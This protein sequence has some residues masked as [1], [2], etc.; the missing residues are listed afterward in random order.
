MR[1]REWMSMTMALLALAPIATLASE[2]DQTRW[3]LSAFTWVK[4]V[5]AEPGAPP[6]A[7]P[8]PLGAE[9]LQALLIPV[10]AKVDGK[11]IPLFGKD[12]LKDLSK[13]LSEAL[14][15]AQPGEDL[16]LISTSKHGRGFLNRDEGL[17]AR[18]FV[19][20]GALNLIV[21]DARLDFMDRYVMDNLQPTF[22]YG[23]RNKAST[24]ML[25]A[26]LATRLRG[27]W[28]S[29]PL[30]APVPAPVPA[31]AAA[32]AVAP[33]PIVTTAPTVTTA[34]AA[35]PQAAP[36]SAQET[37]SYETKAQRL[38]TLKRL[39]DENLLSEAEYQEKREAILKTL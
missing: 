20:D 29:F 5:P 15:L 27:D 9:A 13:A 12:E 1:S 35:M 21:H 33:A 23:S 36:E 25:Q 28:L 32:P 14:A 10:Q 38:R 7:H 22:I 3:N 18:L 8:A 6:N 19:R 11:N 39:R 26:P 16:I 2:A 4:R 30:A 24:A 17:T 37:A 31:V 34:P